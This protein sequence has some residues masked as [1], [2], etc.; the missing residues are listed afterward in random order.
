MSQDSLQKEIVKK[1]GDYNSNYDGLYGIVKNFNI[2]VR[3]DGGFSCTTEL[4]AMGEVL[5]SLKNNFLQSSYC[6]I[7]ITLNMLSKFCAGKTVQF[8]A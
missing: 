2:S 7:P 4:I 6:L 8:K 5:S 3:P 1:K